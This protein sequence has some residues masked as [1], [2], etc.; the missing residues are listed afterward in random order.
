MLID[1]KVSA[2]KTAFLRNLIVVLALFNLC[3][4][5]YV[6]VAIKSASNPAAESN[7]ITQVVIYHF[8]G[9]LLMGG[10]MVSATLDLKDKED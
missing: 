7:F 4:I 6:R 1:Q 2:V 9:S 5:F 8:I 3:T 10:G